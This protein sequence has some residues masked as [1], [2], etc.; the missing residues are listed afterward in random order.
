[1]PL[2]PD[3]EINAA[4]AGHPKWHR[5]GKTLV[6]RFEFPSFMDAMRFVNRV[7]SIAEEANHHP[8][9]SIHY[10]QVDLSLWSHDSG[11]VTR[12]DL[13]MVERIDEVFGG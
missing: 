5:E 2:L 4:L 9:I 6:R 11:G 1:M 13:R 3:A 12:R 7:A 8:D 10:T